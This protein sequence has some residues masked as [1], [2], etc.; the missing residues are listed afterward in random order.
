MNGLLQHLTLSLRLNFRS[1]QAIIYGYVVPIFFLFAFGS[2]FATKPPLLHDMGRL[3]TVTIL[4]GA[5]FGMPTTMVAE[6]ER[7]VWRRY[8]LLPAATGGIILSAMVARFVIILSA[9]VI[10][11]VL[12]RLIYKTP[13]PQHPIDMVGAFIFVCFAF[14]GLGLVIAMVSDNVPA[15]QAMG[16]AIFLPLIIIGGVG[17]R[18]ESLPHWAGHVA[19]FLPG[20]YAVDALQACQLGP[21]LIA[22]RFD[23][24]SL[25]VIGLA[26]ILAGAKLFRWD[27]GQKISGP[28]RGWVALAVVGWLLVGLSAEFGSRVLAAL[29]PTESGSVA[30]KPTPATTRS[31][32][33]TKES[34][35]ITPPA[36]A[37]AP[38]ENLTQKEIDSITYDD[39]PDD[40]GTVTPLAPDL[41]SLDDDGRKRMEN[42]ND[43]LSDWPPGQVENVPQRVR[44]LLSLCAVADIVEDQHEGQIPYVVFNYLRANIQK[45]QLAKAVAWD[46]LNPD[47]GTAL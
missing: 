10:Q 9:A 32:P 44:N 17:V 25:T 35:T 37:K 30:V 21:G 11:I 29:T 6:R 42:F 46:V 45:D 4:G 41:N 16:Q 26:A 5:C 15:V 7:G 20:V 31:S 43:A 40:G 12:A 36:I 22:Q 27:V 47:K 19:K 3:L 39:L 13:F 23:L 1:K 24:L 38:W 2:V 18:L 14:L 8:R 28:A 34:V 33:S